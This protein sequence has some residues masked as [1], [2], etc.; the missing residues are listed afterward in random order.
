MKHPNLH[1][2]DFSK[3]FLSAFDIS[4]SLLLDELISNKGSN[5]DRLAKDWETLAE[6]YKR[7]YENVL[8]DKAI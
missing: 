2:L 1:S 6:D 8:E 4:G 5:L 7:A 3:G